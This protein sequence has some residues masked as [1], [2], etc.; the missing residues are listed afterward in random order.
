MGDA[1]TGDPVQTTV[2]TI[3]NHYCSEEKNCTA[4]F[5]LG[6]IIYEEG[7]AS[8]TDQKF[9][10]R[11]ETP[12]AGVDLPFYI[13]FGNHDYLGCKKCYF[14]Y[15]KISQKWKMPSSYYTQTFDSVM[16]AVIDTENF[17]SE[18]QAWLQKT[19]SESTALHK[20]VLGHR[21]IL[22]DEVEKHSEE[23]QGKKELTDIVCTQADYYV[24]GH[25]HILEDPGPLEGCTVKLLISG[26]A[27][28]TPRAVI[29]NADSPFYA[30]TN[31]F[32]A[33]KVQGNVVEYS[34]IDKNGKVLNTHTTE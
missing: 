14:D 12:Y 26:T 30:L 27:G 31:G 32:L 6:D 22:S 33:F 15:A 29:K 23:W 25:A 1:G 5:L 28:S 11:F 10:T 34:F 24:S 2:A 21:P 16:F 4:V 13:V 17:D 8:V 19:L 3:I 7:V 18:Q 9:Q 20:V